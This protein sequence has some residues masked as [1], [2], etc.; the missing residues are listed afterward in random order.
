MQWQS[1]WCPKR[2]FVVADFGFH[3]CKLHVQYTKRAIALRRLCVKNY[4]N[5]HIGV[6]PF[7]LFGVVGGVNS[8]TGRCTSHLES[9]HVAK[10]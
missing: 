3:P 7:L 8:V 4:I 5:V 2:G 6:W 10:K 1:P 9:Q